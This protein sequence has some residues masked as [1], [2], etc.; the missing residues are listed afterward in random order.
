MLIDVYQLLWDEKETDIVKRMA[1]LIG[2]KK[3]VHI[4]NSSTREID[5]KG[6]YRQGSLIGIIYPEIDNEGKNFILNKIKNNIE[7][8]LGEEFSGRVS[9][10][11]QIFPDD[12]IDEVGGQ[13]LE[14]NRGGYSVLSNDDPIRDTA[15]GMKRAI[16]IVG[17]LVG[18]IL[19]SPFLLI[20]PVFIK[21]NSRGPVFF[22]QERVGDRGKKFRLLKFRSMYIN[23][24]AG[25]H[26]KFVTDFIKAGSQDTGVYKMQDDPR[27]TKIGKFI[28]KTSL[29]E[30][31]QFFNVLKGDMSLVGPR[32]PIPYETEEYELWHR[33]RVLAAKPGITGYWQVE[34]RSLT[35]FD[36]MVRMDIQY[37]KNWSIWL[38]I[39]LLFKTPWAVLTARGAC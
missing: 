25:L 38:D 14:N 18:I 36:G 35:T 6:W 4:L 9:I 27:V 16:D 33:R 2:F 20:I 26:K 30:L 32:P 19:F 34:G 13:K 12:V 24:D 11:W 31:P 39:K 15:L 21:L 7:E 23:N 29:D 1:D 22:R 3:L 17:S 28:R 37:I 10:T 8:S 5:C